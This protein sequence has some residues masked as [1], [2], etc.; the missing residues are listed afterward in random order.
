[1]ERSG[2]PG[3]QTRRRHR[4]TR[5]RDVAERIGGAEGARLHLEKAGRAKGFSMQVTGFVTVA[6]GDESMGQKE[7]HNDGE[8]WR[9]DG[10][11]EA[12]SKEVSREVWPGT[13][14]GQAKASRDWATAAHTP[15]SPWNESVLHFPCRLAACS[16]IPR[17]PMQLHA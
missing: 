3:D 8:C 10:E 1:M 9:W 7:R 4:R 6:R 15:E 16:E 13:V 17:H 5:H 14:P 11:V 2:A 12:E